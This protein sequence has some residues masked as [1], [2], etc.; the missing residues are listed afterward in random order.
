MVLA[1]ASEKYDL[2]QNSAKEIMGSTTDLHI[3][4]LLAKASLMFEAATSRAG[5]TFAEATSSA[6]LAVYGSSTGIV[7]SVASKVSEGVVGTETPWTEEMASK[8][9]VN[10]NVLI[11][12]ASEQ[13]YGTPTPFAHSAWNQAGEYAAQATDA[14]ASQYLIVQAIISELV[15]GKEPDFTESVMNRLSSAYYTGVPAVV[16]SAS[17]LANEA[18]DSASSVITA[19]FT[20]PASLEVMIDSA[21]SSFQAAVDAASAQIYGTTPGYVEQAASVVADSYSSAQSVASE[22]IYG[23]QPSYF[24]AAQSSLAAAASLAQESISVAIYG[25]PT[26][27][28]EAAANSAANVYASVSSVAGENLSAAGDAVKDS[29]STV[30]SHVSKAVYGPEHGTWESASLRIAAAAESASLQIANMMSEASASAQSAA[31]KVGSAASDAT[32]RVKDE[33]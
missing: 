16:A 1:E 11:A 23:T 14:A 3:Q 12:R 17:S 15:V 30:S 5:D 10:Y 26:G 22:A 9:A 28:V 2:V 4:K 6:S 27:V 29:Y 31:S 13:I 7:E 25:T 19:V 33:L 20:P 8:A 21:S 32:A 18:Y 24:E